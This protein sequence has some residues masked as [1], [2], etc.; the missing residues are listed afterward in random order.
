MAFNITLQEHVP[1][2]IGITVAIC[3]FVLFAY[4]KLKSFNPLDEPKGIVLLCIMLVEWID[5]MVADIVSEDYVDRM[6]PF[7]GTLAV[8]ILLANYVGLLG[9]QNPT[10][11]LSV[12]LAITLV[13][14]VLFQATDIR[15]KG[16]GGYVKS[17]FEPVFLFV[18]SNVFSVLAPLISMSMRLFG[19]IL[20]GSIIMSLLYS[21]TGALS[22]NIFPFLGG[23]DPIG[24]L[25]GS[26]LH[27]Y[28]D[29]FSGFLQMYL[30]I[31]LVM[32]F[33]GTR[34]PEKATPTVQPT[35]EGE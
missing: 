11:N 33:T 5:G 25:I 2:I 8:Y 34:V 1:V 28:F 4:R 3:A 13:A 19:N 29:L 31:M 10:L 12:T 9:F 15:Y 18:I 35:T 21:A 23:L 32:V 30:Y 24:P 17:Y 16:F 7:V 14:W 22:A 6:G 20:S 27:L 26:I